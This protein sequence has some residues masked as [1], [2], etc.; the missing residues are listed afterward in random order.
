MYFTTEDTEGAEIALLVR[1]LSS[2]VAARW[3]KIARSKILAPWLPLWAVAGYT[4]GRAE[5]FEVHLL[6]MVS[7]G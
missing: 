7:Q 4:P 3:A 5:A 1:A 2:I 6:G